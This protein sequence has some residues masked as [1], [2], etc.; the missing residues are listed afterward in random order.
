ML[1]DVELGRKTEIDFINGYLIKLA[2]ERSIELS[3]HCRIVSAIHKLN[4]FSKD[5]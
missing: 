1:Q 2:Q 3:E 5:K 4:F